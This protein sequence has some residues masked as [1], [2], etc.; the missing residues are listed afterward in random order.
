MSLNEKIPAEGAADIAWMRSLAE[1]GAR[2][3][4]RGG[5]ILFGAGII[6]GLG[7]L[8]HWAIAGGATPWGMAAVTPVWLTAM[9]VFMVFL[10]LSIWR[11]KS[12]PGVMTAGNRVASVAWSAAGWG[13]FAMSAC[14]AAVSWRLGEEAGF[15]GL[16]LFP[17]VIM[18]FYGI[19]W[20]VTAGA[21]RARP[22]WLLAVV[23]FIAAPLL[24]L[25]TGSPAQYLAYAGCLFLL[26]ALP[27]LLMMR[28]AARS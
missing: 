28:A 9:A 19:G 14:F 11:L 3:P 4:F 15:A 21:M 16:S 24:A 7:S 12:E 26:M 17:S 25:L 8:A 22:L 2:A 13:I 5:S 10:F 6:F 23:S 27:G 18:V 1:E 20:A